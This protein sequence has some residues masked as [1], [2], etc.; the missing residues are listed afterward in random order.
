MAPPL[1]FMTT[2][3]MVDLSGQKNAIVNLAPEH[4]DLDPPSRATGSPSFGNRHPILLRLDF[5]QKGTHLLQ[6]FRDQRIVDPAP[7][8]PIRNHPG[9]LQLLQVKGQAGLGRT[10]LCLEFTHTA[11]PSRQE[12]YYL[13][14]G[15][16]GHGLET[17]E[18]RL[19]LYGIVGHG[20]KYI[21]PD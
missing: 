15:I 11:F 19:S 7:V 2:S 10:Q 17:L 5:S 6:G 13:E 3:R 12:L 9:L 20:R 1:L 18:Q 21:N 14:A 16:L 4:T 8:P